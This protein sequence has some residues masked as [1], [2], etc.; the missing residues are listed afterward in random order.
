MEVGGVQATGVEEDARGGDAG[1]GQDGEVGSL[2]EVDLT[3][4]SGGDV[5]VG[6]RV[7]VELEVDGASGQFLLEISEP[8]D[9]VGLSQQLG[10][11]ACGCWEVGCHGA[12]SAGGGRSSA[13]G[14]IAGG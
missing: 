6:R 2:G 14:S 1:T 12:C 5:G 13:A 4:L 10:D 9:S 3:T 11:E 8:S 7:E